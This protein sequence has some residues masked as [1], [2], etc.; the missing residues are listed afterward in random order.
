MIINI[1]TF[2]NLPIAGLVSSE[3]TNTN[4]TNY[5]DIG[6]VNISLQDVALSLACMLA[7]TMTSRAVPK[8]ASNNQNRIDILIPV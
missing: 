4:S 6:A 8:S 3:T 2:I 1:F 5:T 7:N